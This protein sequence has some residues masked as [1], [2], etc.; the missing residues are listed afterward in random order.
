[1]SES[2]VRN[3]AR[4]LIEASGYSALRAAD[5]ADA[6]LQLADG[7]PLERLRVLLSSPN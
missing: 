3:K 7:L 2:A 1:M 6:T 5:I 4:M